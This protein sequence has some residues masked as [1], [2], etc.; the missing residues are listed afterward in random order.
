MSADQAPKWKG[1]DRR[2]PAAV[3]ASR[4]A[5]HVDRYG[6]AGAEKNLLARAMTT[7]NTIAEREPNR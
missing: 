4:I 3:T 5:E 7:L 6:I 1:L 2:H